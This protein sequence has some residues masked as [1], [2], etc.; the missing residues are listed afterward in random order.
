M[1]SNASYSTRH[2]GK[3]TRDDASN[4]RCRTVTTHIRYMC[5]IDGKRTR[6]N[7]CQ[8]APFI[9]RNYLKLFEKGRSRVVKQLALVL[10]K[11]RC[12]VELA[13]V[14]DRVARLL[15]YINDS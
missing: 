3:F 8:S 10:E 9:N 1:L 2:S 12:Y 13:K 15:Y 7:T 4:G 14:A 6:V 11:L 5:L